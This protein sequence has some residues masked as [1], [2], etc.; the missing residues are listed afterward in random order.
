MVPERDDG[1]E[2]REGLDEIGSDD[3]L[4]PILHRVRAAYNPPPET[5][6]DAMWEVIQG[7]LEAGHGP[8]DAGNLRPVG[9]TPVIPIEAARANRRPAFHKTAGW[10]VAAAALLVLGIGIG[11]MSAP[12]PALDTVMAEAPDPTAM[13]LTAEENLG[14]TES[15]LTL[16]RQGAR[17][18]HLDPQVGP[19]ARILLMQTRLL[20]D[21]SNEK[22]PAM[23][24][25]LE[26]LELVLVQ[27]VGVTDV[28]PHDAARAR[29]E[30]KLA[31]QGL[32][33]RDVLP[34]IQALV[35]VGS[36]L[37]GT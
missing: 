15:L 31:L 11:R 34:R 20:L 5:P 17:E 33:E 12:T 8:P 18:G 23:H 4:D 19:S 27:I 28:G 13:R 14:R 30:L 6:R 26:D 29:T 10:A 35:P 3:D 36:G 21:A 25:L 24:Q 22:D 37:S 7:A 1:L 9:G 2:G 16:V 32:E